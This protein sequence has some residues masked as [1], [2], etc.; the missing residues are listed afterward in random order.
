MRQGCELGVHG[1]D[2]WNSVASARAELARIVKV[3][4][5]PRTG[6][7]M[8][9]L[10][11]DENTFHVLEEAG[12][13][14]DS[15]LGYNETIG[16]RSGTTQAFRPLGV[17][18]LLEL[19][20]HIQDGALFFSHRLDLSEQEAW[21]RCQAVIDNAR[22][23][24]GVLTILWHD[25]SHGPERFWGEFYARVVVQLKSLGPW[26]GTAAQVVN[27]FRQRR[28]VAFEFVRSRDGADQLKLRHSGDG[29]D[30]PLNIRVYSPGS[31]GRGR[32]GRGAQ[33]VCTA[34][35]AWTGKS[36]IDLG[37]LLRRATDPSP[38]VSDPS[39][40]LLAEASEGR[41]PH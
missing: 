6:I 17:Q 13:S 36:E 40:V 14:Y 30:P 21:K 29:I 25:R 41:R 10:L 20:M 34:D 2:A 24:G 26:F 37:Q 28:H 1:I 12:Y 19:P 9:W 5:E 33:A 39:A 11:R 18:A 15:S 35:C 22:K 8:H 32:Q 3:S 38:A 23:L 4:G 31:V 7:R 27:W 16:Y